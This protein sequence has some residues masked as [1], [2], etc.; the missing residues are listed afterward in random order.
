MGFLISKILNLFNNSDKKFKL[1]IVGIQNA[2]KTTILYR[3]SLGELIKTNP[4]IGANIEEISHQN[5]KF[6]AFDL[7]GQE[8]MRSVWDAYYN[9]VNGII[10]VIDST[11]KDNI[12]ESKIELEKLILREELKSAIILIYANKQD[13]SGCMKIDEII[14]RY[15]LNRIKNHTWQIQG[16]SGKTGEG[17]VNGLQW[18]ADKLVLEKENKNISKSNENNI[19]EYGKIDDKSITSVIKMKG[20]ERE[21]KFKEIDDDILKEIEI[22][23]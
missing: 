19:K 21:D 4:T 18:L 20:K 6:Q 11:D 16:C 12:D 9:N 14:K 22:K 10:Y 13:V 5:I 2:G 8:S 23:K 3:L 7:G 1:I 17:L 15:D